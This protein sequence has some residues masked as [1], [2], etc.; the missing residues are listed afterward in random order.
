MTRNENYIISRPKLRK[1]E[2]NKTTRFLLPSISLTQ[3]KTK[4]RM[5]EYY[6]F[7]NCYI[8][9]KQTCFYSP[10]Y[11]YL[12]FNPTKEALKTFN[13][14]YDIYRTYPNFV[15]DYIV[16]YNLIVLVFKVKDKWIG[17]YQKFKES[18]YSEMNQSG[19]A[20]LF[21]HLDVQS[22]KVSI[23]Q[24]NLVITR[25]IEYKKHLEQELDC[26]I[27]SKAE[28]MSKIDEKEFFNYEFKI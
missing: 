21:K 27:D 20:E 12:V 7:V 23:L 13:K 4:L 18:K 26:Q 22:G 15:R 19:Y 8:N 14:F 17:A 9:H 10:N 28:L 16:D 5:L 24:Q 6:G 3:E 2:V 1:I 11:L 25:H